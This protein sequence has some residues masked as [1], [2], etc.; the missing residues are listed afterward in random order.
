MSFSVS[1]AEQA[2]RPLLFGDRQEFKYDGCVEEINDRGIVEELTVF[3]KDGNDRYGI[4]ISL[5]DLTDDGLASTELTADETTAV[6]TEI[7]DPRTVL[8]VLQ[9]PSS[10]LLEHST[11][12]E[13]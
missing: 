6:E 2:P 9:W 11:K 5:I 3:F 10:I 12:I 1:P 8:H 4:M 13:E 7:V